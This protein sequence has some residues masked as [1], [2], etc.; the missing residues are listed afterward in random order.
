MLRAVF[1]SAVLLTLAHSANA[2]MAWPTPGQKVSLYACLSVAPPKCIIARDI[3]TG[4]IYNV[5]AAKPKV[6]PLVARVTGVLTSQVSF[7]P[8]PIL[9][10][11]WIRYTKMRCPKQ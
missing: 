11:V 7:C 10:P 8:G 2:Q 4:M 3:K 9:K 5:T 1:L 6:L